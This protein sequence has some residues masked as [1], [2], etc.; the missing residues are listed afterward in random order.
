MCGGGGWGGGQDQS[1]FHIRHRRFPWGLCPNRWDAERP[2]VIFVLI[3]WF[4]QCLTTMW[5]QSAWQ[6]RVSSLVSLT[7]QVSF[8]TLLCPV[9]LVILT[10]WS[11]Q[12]ANGQYRDH[13]VGQLTRSAWSSTDFS[14]GDANWIFM[15]RTIRSGWFDTAG[16][17]DYDRLRPL[18]YPRWPLLL[19][20]LS[21]ST[22]ITTNIETAM[23]SSG[24]SCF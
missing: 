23:L 12:R 17:E 2:C 14:A 8:S 15:I 16:Q 5:L 10:R 18:A 24:W 19:S 22:K 6:A 4:L 1:S 3:F 20:D 13:L 9:S 21:K 7:R 11:I